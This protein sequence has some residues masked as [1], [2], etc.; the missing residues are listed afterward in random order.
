[1]ITVII[2]N[3]ILSLLFAVS[4]LSYSQQ[5]QKTEANS[6][7]VEYT[8]K[9]GLPSTNISNIV[10][11]KDGYIWLSGIEGTYRFNGYEFEE[12]GKEY[13]LSKMQSMYYDSVKNILYFA[14]PNNFIT[15]NGREFKVYSGKEGYRINGSSGQV[16]SFINADRKGRIWI[17]SET[18]YIDKKHNGGLVRFENESFTVYDSV[19]FPLDNATGFIETPGGDLIFTSAGSNTQTGE[20]A[21]IALYKDGVFRR[22]DES[23]GIKMQNA[24]TTPQNLLTAIDKKGNTWIAF[25][26]VLLS[27]VSVK[28][29]SGVLMYDGVN[30]HQYNDFQDE[31]EKD[32][33][34]FSVYYSWKLDKLYLTLSSS[35]FESFSTKDKTLFELVDGKW[36]PSSI[37]VTIKSRLDSESLKTGSNF[38]YNQ[39]YFKKKDR[40]FPE[41]LVLLTTSS[42]QATSSKIPNQF[43]TLKN[44]NWEKY[45]AFSANPSG[46]T[47]DASIVKTAKGFGLFY[48]NHSKMLTLKD[49]LLRLQGGIPILFTDKNG[50]VWISF[51]YS[52]IPAYASSYST[53]I[54][55]W[56]GQKLK[57]YTVKDGLRSNITFGVIQDREMRIWIPT[58]KGVTSAS[59]I[60]NSQGLQNLKFK[61][62]ESDSRG[63]YNASK[64][65]ETGKG[66]IYA[67][68]DYVRPRS[69]DLI[70]ADFFLGKFDGEKFIEIKSPFTGSE[71]AKKY[72]T[73]N[74]LEDDEGRIWFLGHF[75]DNVK[76]ISSVN[77]RIMLFDG[78][79]WQAPPQNWNVPSKQLHY[80]GKLKNG[81]YF[82]AAGGFFV[83]NGNKFIELSDS[84]DANAD[85]RILKSASVAGTKT[86]LMADGN[87]YMR[88]RTRGLVIFDGTHLKFYTKKD[89][90]PSANLGNPIVD[91][92][93]NISFGFSSGALVVR[94][95]YFQTYWD[96]ENIVAGGP[97]V[98]ILDGKGNLVEYY[99]GTGIYINSSERKSYPLKICSVTSDTQ[100]YYYKF[101][102]R[103]PYFQNSFVFNYAALNY[104]D[105]SQTSYEHLLEGFDREWSRPSNLSFVEYQNLPPGKYRFRIKGITSNGMKSDEDFYSFSISP[106]W[107][108]SWW[109]FGIYFIGFAGGLGGVRKYELDRRREKEKKHFLEA[110]NARKTKELDEARLLQHS[111]LPRELPQLPNLDIA[112]FMKTAT[113]VGGDYYDFYV[114]PDGTLTVLLGDAT[115]HGMMSGMMVSIMKSLF[116]SERS[117]KELKAF[118]ENAS[119]AIKDMQLGRL[120]MALT[121]VRIKTDRI[122]T[123]NAGM[124]PLFIFRKN[125]LAVE[126]VVINN[127]P[128]GAMKGIEY[129]VKELKIEKGDTLLLMSDGFAELKNGS[130][131]LYGYTRAK[132]TFENTALKEPEEIVTHLREEGRNWTGGNEPEDD[133][134]FV[135]IKVK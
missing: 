11:T 134:T 21:F 114:H 4:S 23:A 14:S 98:S 48:Q 93:G 101:P 84:V 59:E 47:N 72:Q 128:L 39:I 68:Q 40:F 100:S 67:W 60:M 28:N 49:N 70:Q 96:D 58:S 15:F 132:N 88:L 12:V 63:F 44:G 102:E 38:R 2:R 111:M 19:S 34:P 31:F 83:F 18:P 135:L 66:E 7:I 131:E 55:I 26:G 73:F 64:I 36:I 104:K 108:R 105:P 9:E 99:N 71:N 92:K 27:N 8:S 52:E 42:Y 97:Y 65:I 80:V 6:D 126:E 30:F 107:Y 77:S 57:G 53:G 117:N 20:G 116:M 118:F 46:E 17:G 125:T 87:L 32:K 110:E 78:K 16:I 25:T 45:D 109:A 123:T 119:A 81:I 35:R 94:G 127:M 41:L 74:L 91:L 120:M 112:V 43:F 130:K 56:D 3:I 124:P 86:N 37:L 62:I 69:K 29:T 115:G 82:L 90:L 75:A 113:E 24:S 5:R 1:M 103:F 76:D 50:I 95:N 121:C 129:D 106:P 79:S 10:Q 33:R 85:F 54:N 89:G 122:V 133:V 22:I 51:S 13:G 61:N